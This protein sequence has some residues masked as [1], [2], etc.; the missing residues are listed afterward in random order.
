MLLRLL[1]NVTEVTTEHQKWPK[2]STKSMKSS[3]FAR[4]AKKK[5]SPRSGLYLLVGNKS[6]AS[7]TSKCKAEMWQKENRYKLKQVNVK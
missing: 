4:M 7:R 6:L 5:V 1:L 3:F 2:I